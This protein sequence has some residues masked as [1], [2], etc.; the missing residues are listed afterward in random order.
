MRYVFLS[1]V[2]HVAFFGMV[3]KM[4]RPE[5]IELSSSEALVHVIIRRPPAPLKKVATPSRNHP[6][7]RSARKSKRNFRT[8]RKSS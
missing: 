7:N 2:L 1:G 8:I 3:M 4:H 6:Q 5:V